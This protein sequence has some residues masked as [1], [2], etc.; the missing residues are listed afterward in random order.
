ME[1]KKKLEEKKTLVVLFLEDYNLHSP[2]FVNALR[3]L[4]FEV[5]L[6]QINRYN[7]EL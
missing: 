6:I 4:F 5:Y 7:G 1:E 2:F 3:L